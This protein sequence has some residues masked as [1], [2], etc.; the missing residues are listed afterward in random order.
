MAIV[1]AQRGREVVETP[2]IAPR[3]GE[4]HAALDR[5]GKDGEVVLSFADVHLV[6]SDPDHFGEIQSRIGIANM[7]PQQTPQ[8]G[9]ALAENLPEIGRAHV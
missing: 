7:R 3:G 4:E 9:V 2:M 1:Q 5:V 8:T 6:H